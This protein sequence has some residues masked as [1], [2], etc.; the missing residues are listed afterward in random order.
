MVSPISSRVSNRASVVD[1][2]EDL[3]IAELIE[4]KVVKPSQ[5]IYIDQGL[6]IPDSYDVDT[7]RALVQDPFHIWVYWE[8]KD[9]VFTSLKRVFPPNIA[10]SFT[11]V[12]KITELK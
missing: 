11:P 12:L 4:E 3:P 10:E 5:E 8:L 1:F 2:I 7:I 6:P 9:R